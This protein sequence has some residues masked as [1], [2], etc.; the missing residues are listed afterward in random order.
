MIVTP[1]WRVEFEKA[2][3]EGAAAILTVRAGD[4]SD[5]R[6]GEVKSKV[7]DRN[8][9]PPTILGRGRLPPGSGDGEPT[10]LADEAGSQPAGTGG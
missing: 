3:K 9:Q 5:V 10:I 4:G 6:T 7:E 2:K 8:P 1:L